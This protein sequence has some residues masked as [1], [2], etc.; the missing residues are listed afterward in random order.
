MAKYHSRVGAGQTFSL[1]GQ[2]KK[3]PLY[4]VIEIPL[5]AQAVTLPDVL[6]LSIHN[7]GS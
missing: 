6:R 4:C 2:K 3:H 7:L 1:A 5:S